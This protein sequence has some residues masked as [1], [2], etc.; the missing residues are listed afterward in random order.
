MVRWNAHQLPNH[1]KTCRAS[2]E[3]EKMEADGI[4]DVL[5]KKE[6]QQLVK[7]RQK[8]EKFSVV[9]DMGKLPDAVFV[10]DSRKERIAVHEARRLNIPIISIVDT[11]CDPDEIDYVVPGNDDAIR[12]IKLITSRIADAVI[13]G[14][15]GLDAAP[16]DADTVE[17]P[18][19]EIREHEIDSEIEDVV[20]DVV[21]VPLDNDV[22]EINQV[23]NV[24]AHDSDVNE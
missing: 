3:I 4:F 5:P 8:L 20:A 22:V 12:A 1:K 19:G 18:V 24:T 21:E 14:L 13:E 23:D 10:V 6:V 15:E 11:N 17:S 7:E 2:Q 9:C 16:V